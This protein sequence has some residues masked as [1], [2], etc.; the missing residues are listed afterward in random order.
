MV[1]GKASSWGRLSHNN[2]QIEYFNKKDDVFKNSGSIP[3]IPFGMGRSYGDICLNTNGN[4][5]FTRGLNKFISFDSENG[6]LRC[7]AG[8]TLKEI[9]DVLVPQGWMLFVSPGTQY[10]TVGGAIANDIHG[11]N[12]HRFGSF[13]N[14]IKRFILKRT[15]GDLIECSP[16]LNSDWFH[17]T[18]GGMGLTGCILEAEFNLKKIDG[19]WLE[20]E[21]IP[22][23][24]L[25]EFFHLCDSSE[26]NWEYTV[27]WIDCLSKSNRG[28]F[29]RANH[30]NHKAPPPKFT[31]KK[32]PI[33]PPFS[34]INQLSLRPFNQ[35]YY[36]LNKYVKSK[37]F[38]FYQDFFYP[39]D[40]ILE[41]NKAYG[42]KGFYQYQF[43]IPRENGL[44]NIKKILAEISKSGQGS[45]LAVLKT[46]GD[47][48]S[49]GMMSFPEKGITLALDFPNLG[50]KTT[51]L[52]DK[53]DAIVQAAKGKIYLAK[54]ARLSK[55]F[56]ESSYPNLNQFNK[57]RDEG[58]SSDM[59]RRLMGK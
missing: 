51:A 50:S 37:N 27:S 13:G 57:Y 49:V 25:E 5:W 41:W 9:Q 11:K 44:N 31:Q 54:D 15:N 10:V 1:M 21:T 20:T 45:F 59:S 48:P 58:I 4:I 8:I 30:S 55:A 47:V 12:H 39:L 46:F 40:S 36:S 17:A 52:L 19:P 3:G 24:S 26:E 43:V 38:Q 42:P 18:I 14:H 35:A 56:Y 28:I 53:L 32:L 16:E 6:L 2:Y 7:E 29:L 23:N 34:L 22:Y 33:T